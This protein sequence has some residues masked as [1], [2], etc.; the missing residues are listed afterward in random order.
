MA[1]LIIDTTNANPDYICI[2]SATDGACV[3]KNPTASCG[4]WIG[5]KRSCTG[6]QATKVGYHNVRIGCE[7]GY[8]AILIGKSGA[9]SGRQE[10]DH[11]IWQSP[12]G[13][14]TCTDSAGNIVSYG[15]SSS[16]MGSSSSSSSSS[17]TCTT[18]YPS[19]SQTCNT[20]QI[21]E[22][23]PTANPATTYPTK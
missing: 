14:T 5:N 1:N 23:P 10:A 21:D 9:A 4:P 15:G 13:I 16:F 7:A 18:S 17:A 20:I 19:Y 2:K 11:D 22:T 8:T 12:I 6:V 3:V